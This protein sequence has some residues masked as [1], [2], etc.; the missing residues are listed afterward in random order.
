MPL[1]KGPLRRSSLSLGDGDADAATSQEGADFAATVTLV[2]HHPHGPNT[3]TTT[4]R[5]LDSTLF[6]Q[7]SE[8]DGLVP[9]PSGDK[10]EERL[11][12]AFGAQVK[13]RAEPTSAAPKRLQLPFFAPAA[14]WWARTIL[15]ST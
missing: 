2:P 6:H 9:L 1:L 5:A 15:P 8:N 12:A 7:M 10:E 3:R 14:C 13:L 11:T 4:L